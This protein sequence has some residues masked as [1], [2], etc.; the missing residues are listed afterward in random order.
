MSF[1][2]TCG[3]GISALAIVMILRPLY[4]EAAKWTA[5]FF[6][7]YICF[8]VLAYIS[9]AIALAKTMLKDVKL[10]ESFSVS[11][12][13]L[14]ISYITYISAEICRDCGEG[15]MATKLELLGKLEIML[16]ALPL[17]K[18]V[19]SLGIGLLA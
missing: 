13:A 18:K 9:E 15:G 7:V 19:F 12:K 2:A 5:A 1:I 16:L 14:G 6:T 17:I 8:S 10:D 3:V 4:P 11:V